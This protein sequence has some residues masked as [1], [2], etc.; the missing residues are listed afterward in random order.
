M[1][2]C[3][4]QSDLLTRDEAAAY[5]NVKPQTLACWLTNKRYPLPVLKIGSKVRYRLRD[6]ERFL[7]SR[8]IGGEE[9]N[10]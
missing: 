8:T 3:L 10:S 1:P 6:L 9:T 4:C 2:A 5:L 7:E